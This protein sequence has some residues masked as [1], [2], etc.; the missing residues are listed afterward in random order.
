MGTSHQRVQEIMVQELVQ[1]PH[2]TYIFQELDPCLFGVLKCRGQ[3]VLPFDDDQTATNFLLKIY[4]TFRQTM[5]EL[6]I[7]GAF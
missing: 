6:N 5:I 7:W 3:Y 1:A 4:R 2:T